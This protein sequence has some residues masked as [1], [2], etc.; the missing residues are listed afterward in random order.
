MKSYGELDFEGGGGIID[1]R[2]QV[3]TAFPTGVEIKDGYLFYLKTGIIA[4][5]YVYRNNTWI[6]IQVSDLN[7][8]QE[9]RA[10]L[11]RGVLSNTITNTAQQKILRT[12]TADVPGM[13]LTPRAGSHLIT[14]NSQYKS[15]TKEITMQAV[16]DLLMAYTYLMA[17]PNTNTTHTATFGSGETLDPGVYL[18]AAAGSLAGVL[19]LDGKNNPNSVFI[20]K[21]GG[22]FSTTATASVVLING[23]QA[24]NVYWVVEGAGSL[25]ALNNFK[26]TMLVHEA[27]ASAADGCT[28]EGRLFSTSGAVAITNATITVPVLGP[29][30]TPSSDLGLLE[31]YGIFTSLGA[32]SN[33]GVTSIT[34]DIG[35]NGGAIAGF[36]ASTISGSITIPGMK[37]ALITLSVYQNN[38]LIGDSVR[39]LNSASDVGGAVAHL[40]TTAN[41]LAGQSI[42]LK[43]RVLLGVIELGNRNLTAIKL[44]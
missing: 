34:G 1:L 8:D 3:G 17:V 24:A 36:E 35:T 19:T 27:A 6:K 22:A 44:A 12:P 32:I 20:F 13:T 26:G 39:L 23:A 37:A 25:G 31:T 15:T 18:V 41:I 4:D 10:L 11:I 5:P 9:V 28:I 42:S 38:V 33:T 43:I 29:F 2:I 30:S 16:A 40:Q 14:F 7:L 21:F